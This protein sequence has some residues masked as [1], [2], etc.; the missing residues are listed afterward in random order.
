MKRLYKVI[1]ALIAA[2]LLAA[3]GGNNS[4]EPSAVMTATSVAPGSQP[5]MTRSRSGSSSPIEFAYVSNYYDGNISAYVI[6]ATSGALTQINGSPFS[7]G[8]I[9]KASQ[10]ILRARLHMWRTK[11]PEPHRIRL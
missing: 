6:D 11:A 10:S 8:S 9:L 1:G 5:R 7:A 3:C 4:V 2:A